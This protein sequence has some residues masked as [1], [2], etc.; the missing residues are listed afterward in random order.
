MKDPVLIQN[1]ETDEKKKLDPGELTSKPTRV[2]G[3]SRGF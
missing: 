1:L 2:W 3:V